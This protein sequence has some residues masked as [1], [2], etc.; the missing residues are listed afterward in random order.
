MLR[1]VQCSRR[2]APVIWHGWWFRVRRRVF[3]PPE[4]PPG[5]DYRGWR[6]TW[7][8]PDSMWCRTP[9]DRS[10]IE[11][12]QG[13][14]G[15]VTEYVQPGTPGSHGYRIAFDN[16]AVFGTYLPAPQVIGLTRPADETA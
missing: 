14:Q 12:S 15:T 4:P 2:L 7:L 1:W 13:C 8:S 16:G 9:G 3:G 5:A 10:D 6:V 11:I